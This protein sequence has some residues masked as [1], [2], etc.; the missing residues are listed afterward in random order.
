MK[1]LKN[2]NDVIEIGVF[3]GE[4]LRSFLKN[5]G[6]KYFPVLLKYYNLSDEIM[7]EYHCHLEPHKERTKA[8]VSVQDN[9]IDNNNAE[10][11][12]VDTKEVDQVDLEVDDALNNAS[13]LV[14]LDDKKWTSS[15]SDYENSALYD[16][17]DDM[18]DSYYYDRIMRS[19]GMALHQEIANI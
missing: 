13:D 12:M 17:E 15:L 9:I 3:A 4:T 16:P 6:K 8:E 10:N 14:E 1:T 19:Q 7:R 5:Y 18:A 11:N 2:P